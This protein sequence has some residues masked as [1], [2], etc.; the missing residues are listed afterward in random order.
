MSGNLVDTVLNLLVFGYF[1][2]L[3]WL[4]MRPQP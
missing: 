2:F 4:A 1:G 3:V